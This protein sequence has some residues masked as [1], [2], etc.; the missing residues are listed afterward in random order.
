M[1][2]IPIRHDVT[3]DEFR[4]IRAAAE[5][6]VLKGAVAHWPVVQAGD[7]AAYLRSL[8]GSGEV[9]YMRAPPEVEGRLHYGAT[10]DT[11]NFT[12]ERATLGGFLDLLAAEAG[13]ARPATLVVQGLIADDHAPGFAA[14]NPLALLPPVVPP[15]LWVGNAGKVATH[16]DPLENIA[17]VAAG[18][19]RFMLFAPEQVANL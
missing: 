8:G 16:Y 1:H 12:L 14:A 4:E 7:A 5:P 11:L 17:C 18:K 15:R 19:R 3:A 10:V 9:E 2:S 6:V 13:R